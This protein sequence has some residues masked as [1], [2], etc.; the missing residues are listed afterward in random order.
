[1]AGSV[2]TPTCSDAVIVLPGIMGSE[3]VERET[4]TV[5]WGLPP[6]GYIDLWTRDSIW[7]KLK[8]TQRERDGKPGRIRAT[9]LL[10]APAFA[11]VMRGVEPYSR[12]VAAIQ[13]ITNDRDAVLEFPYDWRLSVRY[14]AGEL[15]KA[16][17]RHLTNWRVHP[18]GSP[19][20][21]LVLVAHS[22]GG[23][24]AQFFT[25]KLGG[26]TM[27][28]Q[29]IAIGTP[30]WGA[31]KAIFLLDQG[32]GSPV[33]LP[34]QRLR[35]VAKTLPGIHDLLPSYRCVEENGMTRKLT[36]A[37]VQLLGGDIDL[38]RASAELHD[39]LARLN[40]R[41]LRTLVGVEQP[42]MQSLRLR[43]GVAEPQYFTN[44][45][46]GRIDWRG[47]GTV[48]SQVAAG[49]VEPVSSLPQSHGALARSPEAIAA[50]RAVLTRRRLG[51]PMGGSWI[52]LDVPDTI[53]VGQPFEIYVTSQ[54]DP[55]GSGCRIVDTDT[56]RQVSRPFLVRHGDAMVASAL[57]LRPGLFRVEVQ[58][59]GYSA[60]TQLI[61][62]MPPAGPA[63]E[64]TG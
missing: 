9:R 11:P 20:A 1:M 40:P 28:R 49:G 48:Y 51:P 53:Y 26:H 25:G 59:G 16:A 10:Q 7:E 60:V 39:A 19:D 24:V 46:V 64:V 57:L 58:D 27:V 36:P 13:S 21:K 37:D 44:E 18:N 30:F 34:R 56:N 23:L 61:M 41:D 54:G 15:A 3:L 50:I 32:R 33:P 4:D 2:T 47:D 42:T 22:M 17:D 62:A 29:T 31:V 14:N 35:C 63:D 45:D 8:V 43:D 38:A 55:G 12:L 6:R 52:S 5:L